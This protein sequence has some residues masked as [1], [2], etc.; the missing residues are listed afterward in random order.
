MPLCISMV[1]ERVV[2]L[3]YVGW[4]I[5]AKWLTLQPIDVYTL[6]EI[7][8]WPLLI[9]CYMERSLLS[10]ALH[11]YIQDGVLVRGSSIYPTL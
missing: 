6:K 9:R 8:G 10:M 5:D 3:L 2:P 11:R 1:G 7:K 4:K